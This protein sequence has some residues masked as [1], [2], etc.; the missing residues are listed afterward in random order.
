MLFRSYLVG[1]DLG[2]AEGVDESSATRSRRTY[3][4]D[5]RSIFYTTRKSGV[6]T[7]NHEGELDTLLDLVAPASASE[8]H[9]E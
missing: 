9:F 6:H 4:A 7:N 1:Q 2:I 8:R 3:D 5:K